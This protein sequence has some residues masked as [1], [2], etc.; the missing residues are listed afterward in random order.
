MGWS[1]GR[2][3]GSSALG[4]LGGEMISWAFAHSSA[5]SD[6]LRSEKDF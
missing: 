4:F 2:S 6:W 1:F 5:I 3:F